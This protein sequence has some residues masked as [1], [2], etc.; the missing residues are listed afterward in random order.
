M[1]TSSL[2]QSFVISSKKGASNFVKLF[3]EQE[4]NPPLR[5]VNIEIL[6]KEKL[7]ELI[8]ASRK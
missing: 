8:N 6:S 4:K 7:K 2:K 5:D 1:A 3:T